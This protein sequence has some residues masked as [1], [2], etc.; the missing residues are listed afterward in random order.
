V[1]SHKGVIY[2]THHSPQDSVI[3]VKVVEML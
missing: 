1:L 3:I 2:T